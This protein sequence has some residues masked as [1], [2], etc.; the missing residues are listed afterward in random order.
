MDISA[1]GSPYL[2]FSQFFNQV[3]QI[4][5]VEMSKKQKQYYKW[6][7][8]KNYKAL[9]RGIKGSRSSFVNI[10]MELKKCCNHAH[11]IRPLEDVEITKDLLE[12]SLQRDS[13]SHNFYNLDVGIWIT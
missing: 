2:P 9:T 8:T 5:R 10:I 6:I 12:V 1:L 13:S 11:L 7:L 4:L 3:E